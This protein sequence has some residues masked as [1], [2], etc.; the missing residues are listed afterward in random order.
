MNPDSVAQLVAATFSELSG[1]EPSSITRSVV[2]EKGFFAGFQFRAG[3]LRA[4]WFA[5][6][7]IVKFCDAN[8]KLLRKVKM[9]ERAKG[10]A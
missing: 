2:L 8:G 1:S 9:D 4:V 10:A 3:N 5:E 7:G 6:S